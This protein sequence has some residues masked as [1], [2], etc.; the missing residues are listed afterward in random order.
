MSTLAAGIVTTI[1]A[2]VLQILK[3]LLGTDKPV[4]HTVQ[5][6]PGEK[7]N[8]AIQKKLRELDQALR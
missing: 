5:D 6:T 1:V 4:E 3:S 7:I 2:V 8:D